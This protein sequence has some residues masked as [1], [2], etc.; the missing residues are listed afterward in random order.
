M[1]ELTSNRAP[2]LDGIPIEFYKTFWGDIK[3]IFLDS[4]IFAHETGQLCESQYQGV[5]T[6]IPKPEKEL[7]QITNYRPITLLNCDYK[8]VAK[9]LNNRL[10][11]LLHEIIGPQQNGFVGGRYIGHNIRLLFDV[12]DYMD[13]KNKPGAIILL[14]IYKAFDSLSWPF[15]F[16]VFKAYKF[17]KYLVSWIKILYHNTKCCVTNNNCLSPFFDIR[18]GVRQGDPVSPTIFIMCIEIMNKAL[19]HDLGYKGLFI[20][21]TSL[22][23]SMFANDTV[24]FLD[25]RA[26][27]FKQVFDILQQFSVFSGLQINLEKS[28][29][30][31]I[32]TKRQ[33]SNKPLYEKGL[34]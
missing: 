33:T 20:A 16:H 21:D 7:L 30:F 22:K 23:S 17:G 3:D 27:Q 34:K 12:I 1:Q 2:G 6:L 18:K 26:S 14:D 32:G 4:I 9:V 28:Q 19:M 13:A 5:I 10:K 24:I 29:A 31:Y 11:K 15:I 25:G 8:I